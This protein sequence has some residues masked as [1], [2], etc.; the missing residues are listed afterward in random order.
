LAD[1]TERHGLFAY[2]DERFGISERVFDDYL[3][4]KRQTSW[5]L[6]KN[7]PQ[8]SAAALLKVSKVGIKAFNKVGAYV[9]PTTRLI[10]VFGH[11]ATRAKIEIGET[12]LQRLL[13]NEKLP[14]DLGL[15]KGYVILS[16]GKDFILGLG[17]YG[18]GKVSS[19]LP[20][21]DL[22]KEMFQSF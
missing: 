22:R 21:K 3:L 6:M 17:F 12:H 1:E 10:Q 18:Q 11:K 13:A 9:K 4:F 5:S 16:L 20:K 19:Q 7:A 8:I 15:D 14:M 2:L